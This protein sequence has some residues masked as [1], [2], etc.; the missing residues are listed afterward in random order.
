MVNPRVYKLYIAT[1]LA[2]SIHIQTPTKQTTKPG[3]TRLTQNQI[4]EE[5]RKEL[6]LLIQHRKLMGN[7]A[8]VIKGFILPIPEPVSRL[9]HKA[10][11]LASQQLTLLGEDLVDSPHDEREKEWQKFYG[12]PPCFSSPF[13]SHSP[14]VSSGS[15]G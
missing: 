9:W 15:F 6:H 2:S 4:N 5:L 8:S 11:Q 13:Q 7:G 1:I 14:L 3:E 10:R 12:Q